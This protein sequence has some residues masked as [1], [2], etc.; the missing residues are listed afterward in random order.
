MIMAIITVNSWRPIVEAGTGLVQSK[1]PKPWDGTRRRDAKE[2]VDT[3]PLVEK[4][5]G[6]RMRQWEY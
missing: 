1:E 3:E 6:L 2:K 4:S 5:N